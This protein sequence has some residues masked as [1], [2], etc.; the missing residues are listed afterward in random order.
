MRF[1]GADA[2]EKCLSLGVKPR[3]RA[4][5][6]MIDLL[7][8]RIKDMDGS[9][10]AHD[11]EMVLNFQGGIA[12]FACSACFAVPSSWDR[13]CP[14]HPCSIAEERVAGTRPAMT[15]RPPAEL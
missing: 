2:A 15:A 4:S 3:K 1:L 13:A 11:Q 8:D 6:S 12:D 14:G 10:I 7:T 9:T 5:I